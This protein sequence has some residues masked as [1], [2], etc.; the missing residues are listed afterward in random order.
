MHPRAGKQRCM[1]LAC[2]LNPG[3]CAQGNS[4]RELWTTVGKVVG[5]VFKQGV[6]GTGAGG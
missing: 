2:W 4:A 3:A 5:G 1:E 6:P